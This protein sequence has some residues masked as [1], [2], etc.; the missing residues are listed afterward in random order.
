MLIKITFFNNYG[1]RW[2]GR[3]KVRFPKAIYAGGPLPFLYALYP[4]YLKGPEVESNT[5]IKKDVDT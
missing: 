2:I 4:I 1:F 3:K 5:V